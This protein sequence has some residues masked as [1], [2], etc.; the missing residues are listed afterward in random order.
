MEQNQDQQRRTA[1]NE[2]FQSL[3]ELEDMLHNP[4]EDKTTLEVDTSSAN[5]DQVVESSVIDME[6]FE[7][8]VADIEQYLEQEKGNC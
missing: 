2:F 6:A 4:T 5:D 3:D 8:A 7:E 1:K